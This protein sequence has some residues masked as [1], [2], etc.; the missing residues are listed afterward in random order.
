MLQSSPM[1]E[2]EDEYDEDGASTTTTL[3]PSSRAHTLD[4]QVKTN[5]PQKNGKKQSLY[6][7]ARKES[8]EWRSENAAAAKHE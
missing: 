1:V 6:L 4:R 3:P 8:V 2:E 7:K 5:S